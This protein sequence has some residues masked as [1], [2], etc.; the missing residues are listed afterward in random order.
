MGLVGC[1]RWLCTLAL[2]AS[3]AAAQV[4]E[5][6]SN[7]LRYQTLTRNGL[8]IMLALLPAQVKDYTVLQVA[9]SN[10]GAVP[11]SIRPE[12]FV[13]VREDG[14]EIP[15]TPAR[16]VVTSLMGRASRGDVV[17]LITSYEAGIYG[18]H[19]YKATNGYEHRRQAALTEFTSTKLRAAAAASAIA[20]VQTRLI[21]GQSTDGAVFYQHSGRGLG[22]GRIRVKAAGATY[23]FD[24]LLLNQTP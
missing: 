18:N 16:A 11:Y 5:F 2:L 9:V 1:S 3:G 14:V 7:G 6:E 17:K 4:I 24:L 22:S 10:G 19:E 21:P 15:A 23:E 13:F 8:T 20:L 12:D